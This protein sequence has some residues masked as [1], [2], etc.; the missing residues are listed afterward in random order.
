MTVEWQNV[1]SYSR[2]DLDRTPRSWEA[3]IG[4]VRLTV[5]RWMH[6]KA[7]EWFAS[8]SPGLFELRP[9]KSRGV[10]ESKAEAVEMLHQWCL[11]VL[12]A[13]INKEVET[14]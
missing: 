1:T 2:S 9:L 4:P 5:H 7:D 8:A 12:R 14:R 10:D 11:S 13:M 3:K 6:G